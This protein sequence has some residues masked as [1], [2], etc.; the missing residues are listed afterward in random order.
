V[1]TERRRQ[2]RQASRR[3]KR[4]ANAVPA[5]QPTPVSERPDLVGRWHKLQSEPAADPY[6]YE[7]DFTEA[8]YRGQRGT[9]QGLIWW[10]VGIYRL[11]SPTALLVSTATDELVSYPVAFEGDRFTVDTPEHGRI[12]YQRDKPPPPS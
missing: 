7:I 1:A 8:T 11:E 4:G 10:D 6:P 5:P 3:T 12:V 2:K 9:D